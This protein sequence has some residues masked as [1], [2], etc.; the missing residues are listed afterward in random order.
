MRLMLLRHAKSEKAAPGEPDRDRVLNGR[1]RKDAPALGAYLV[2][3]ALIPESVIV[4]AARRTRET[5]ARLAL[6]LPAPPPVAYDER[7]Y[8]AGPDGVLGVATAAPPAVQSLMLI[9]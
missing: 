8:N 2:R 3:H 1:G 5:W 4:S 9:G 7:L 6:A